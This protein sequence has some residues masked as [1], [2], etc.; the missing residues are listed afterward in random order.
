MKKIVSVLLAFLMLAA[1]CG[2]GSGIDVNKLLNSSETASTPSDEPVT[3][4]SDEEAE[5][6]AGKTV[7]NVY[8][9]DFLGITCTL[10]SEW[11]FYTDDQ[12][13]K[14]NNQTVNA[15]DDDTASLVNQANIIY[16]MYAQNP[17]DGSNVNIN[18]E[19]FTA[20]QMAVM[21]VK[22][23][24]EGQFDMLKS[25]YQNMGFSNINIYYDKITV[26]GKEVDGA[27]LTADINGVNFYAVMFCFKKGNYLANVSLSSIQTNRTADIL[28]CF[29]FS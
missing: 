6:S 20:I 8:K 3:S 22:K 18:L 19:E 1:L 7:N 11:V 4:D 21:D 5:F 12:I 13:A 16:D 23:T 14:L 24:L 28:N 25:T 9:N 27:R 15:M 2:C 29:N 10:P 17:N 26:G